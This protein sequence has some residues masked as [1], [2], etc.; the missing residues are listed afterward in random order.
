MN[1]DC[2]V[3]PFANTNKASVAGHA[4]RREK[5]PCAHDRYDNSE[6]CCEM[7]VLSVFDVLLARDGVRYGAAE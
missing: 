6:A 1:T 2:T 4:A 3:L 7:T 5:P